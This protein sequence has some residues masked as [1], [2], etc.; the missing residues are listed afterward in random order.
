MHGNS[1]VSTIFPFQKIKKGHRAESTIQ[2]A[3]IAKGDV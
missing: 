3:F 2:D 1:V